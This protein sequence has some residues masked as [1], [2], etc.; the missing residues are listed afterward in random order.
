[1]EL[2]NIC[3]LNREDEEIISYFK[4][5]NKIHT[6]IQEIYLGMNKSVIPNSTIVNTQNVE[7]IDSTREVYEDNEKTIITRK[8]QLKNINLD[9]NSNQ[10]INS[11]KK[12]V[13]IPSFLRKKHK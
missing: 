2:V 12:D 1:M 6:T 13:L 7:D 5:H 3:D 4:L 9:K 10:K 11:E 8:P